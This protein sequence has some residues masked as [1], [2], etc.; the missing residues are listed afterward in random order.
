MRQVDVRSVV[1]QQIHV[2]DGSLMLGGTAV[3]LEE[4][5][6][7]L[8]IAVG[9]AALPMSE[10]AYAALARTNLPIRAIVVTNEAAR[11]E[12]RGC[13]VLRGSHPLP[14]EDSLRGAEAVLELLHSANPR[15]AVLFLISGGASAMIEKPLDSGIPLSDVAGFY[16]ALVGSGLPIAQMNVLRKHFSAVKG[17]RLAEAAA[18]ARIQCTLLI[19]DV[20]SNLADVIG[21]G[22]SLPDPGTIADC[23]ALLSALKLPLSVSSFFAGP[24]C[25]ETPR[26]SHDCFARARWKVILSSEHLAEAAAQSARDAGFHV[27]MD[28]TCDEWEYRD[29]ARYLIEHG[30]KMAERH[31]R[32]CLISVG[33]VGVTLS[34][35]PGEGGRN[36]Q[37][38]LWAAAELTRRK[39]AATILSAGSDGIDGNSDAAGAVCDQTTIELARQAGFDVEA[40]LARFNAA[41]LLR[42]VGATIT[43][44][45][46]GNNLRDLRM[47]FFG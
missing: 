40:Q 41:P 26:A 6:E 46:T 7:V 5:A 10:A 35:D 15:T 4:L 8:V 42:A 9:K 28:N 43:T 29:A 3:R 34:D 20:P 24:L 38:A 25:V 23:A 19:S 1:S 45:P 16:R 44:G 31:P 32:C 17:G 47:L 14:D 36:Q 2:A 13:T 33:E 11:R 18:A 22:P 30:A 39:I 12:I 37:F 27:E 21:S